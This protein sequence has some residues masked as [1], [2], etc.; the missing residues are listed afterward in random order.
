MRFLCKIV[1]AFGIASSDRRLGLIHVLLNLGHHVLLVAVE[2]ASRDPL[3]I[4]FGCGCEL[5]R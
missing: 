2:L 3:E 1:T 5:L 4:F